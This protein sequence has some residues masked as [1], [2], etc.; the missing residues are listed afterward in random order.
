MISIVN[1]ASVIGIESYKV[2]VEVMLRGGLRKI[3]LVGLPDTAV[4]ESEQR[5]I[6][7][8]LNSG[9]SMPRG[10]ITISLAPAELRKQGSAFD[11][12]IA[13]AILSSKGDIS[14]QSIEGY[15]IVGELSLSSVIKPVKGMLSIAAGMKKMGLKKIILPMQN[16]KEASYV[17]DIEIYPART[18]MEVVNHFKGYKPIPKYSYSNFEGKSIDDNGELDFDEV[19]GQQIAKRALEIAAAGGHN[20]LLVGSPGSGK[21]MLAQRLPSILPDLALEEALETTKIHSIAGLLDGQ[22]GLIIKRPFRAPHHTISYAGLAGGGPIPRPGEIS[23]AHN[24]VLFLDELLEFQKRVLEVLRQPLEDGYIRISRASTSI[25]YPARFMLVAA[26]NPCPCGFYSDPVRSCKCSPNEI[27]RYFS[28][29]SGPLLDRIDISIFLQALQ[30]E[31]LISKNYNC[32]PSAS[33][34]K[35]VE[36]ARSIQK[37]RFKNSPTFFNAR[38]RTKEIEKFCHL[39]INCQKLMNNAMK[40]LGFTARA[41]TRILKVARTIADLNK[42]SCIEEVDLA[43]AIQYHTIDKLRDF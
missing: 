14:Q 34:K 27:K 15:L 42:K 31:E 23:L 37:E 18:L 38:M 5:V 20:V 32:E 2:S 13:I 40:T 8:I 33:I 25:S 26:T 9:Y 21:T 29:I 22:K 35:R 43:E 1:S 11:L 17:R 24:G 4:R 36:E 19:K 28:R 39:S 30:A 7:A 41:F 3:I 6:S 16:A 12:P 10:L